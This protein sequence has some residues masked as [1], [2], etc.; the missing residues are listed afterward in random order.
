[1]TPKTILVPTD[2]SDCAEQALDYAC[3]LASSIGATVYIVNALGS[4]SPEL[5]LSVTYAMI[6]NVLK[7]HQDA[8]EKL[9]DKRREFVAM[10]APIAKLGDA[11]DVI[12]E[13]ADAID[14]DLIIMGTHGRRGISRIVVGSVAEDIARRA[15]CPV[16]LV[17]TK[18][19][20]R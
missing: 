4:A 17:R 14:A 12:L 20:K 9:A 3:S 13:T 19:A 2:F 18:K 10:A 16:L 6:E 15:A 8:V 1:M 7:G 5:G 11:R